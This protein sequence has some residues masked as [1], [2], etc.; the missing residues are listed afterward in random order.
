[1]HLEPKDRDWMIVGATEADIAQLLS[2]GFT[3]VG[4]DFPVFLHPTTKEEYAL[5]RVERKTGVG[6]GGFTVQADASVTL[7]DDLIRRD[8]TINSMAVGDD[9]V[10]IDP[11][12]GLADLHNHVLRHTSPAFSEDPLRVLRLARFAARYDTFT[13]APE[14][15]ELCRTICAS[16][17]LNELS[18]ERIWAELDKGLQTKSP[19]RFIEVLHDCSAILGCKIMNEIFSL[20]GAKEERSQARVLRAIRIVKPQDRLTITV[21]AVASSPVQNVARRISDCVQN[22]LALRALRDHAEFST[23]M[24]NVGALRNGNTFDDL[25]MAATALEMAGQDFVLTPRQLEIGKHAMLQVKATDTD[26][27]GLTGKDLGRELDIKRGV[28]LLLA[29]NPNLIT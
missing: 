22:V 6:Y 9:G 25:V 13:I 10:L 4:A 23:F 5:A 15:M 3:Q 7:E 29:V 14:T 21:A 24:R 28:E 1:M 12:G 17:E 8:L 11:Y 26:F 19:D 27:A 20:A 2:D 16:G 18:R